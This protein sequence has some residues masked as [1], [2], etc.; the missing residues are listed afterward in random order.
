MLAVSVSEVFF[1]KCNSLVLFDTAYDLCL[2]VYLIIT[3]DPEK[4]QHYLTHIDY[5][6]TA[7]VRIMGYLIYVGYV[8]LF[9][10]SIILPQLGFAVGK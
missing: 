2:Y 5:P 1:L 8:I 7:Y 6:F 9:F 3:M 10:L 4:Y